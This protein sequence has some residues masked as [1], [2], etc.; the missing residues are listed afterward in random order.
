M[1]TE[2]KG[3]GGGG[4]DVCSKCKG[5]EEASLQGLSLGS[6]Y[7]VSLPASSPLSFLTHLG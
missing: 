7:F 5:K 3:W 1:G 4:G 6:S 2:N